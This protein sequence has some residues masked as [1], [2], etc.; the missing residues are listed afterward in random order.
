M[1]EAEASHI[2]SPICAITSILIRGLSTPF[3]VSVA[4]KRIL[5]GDNSH[6]ILLS[7]EIIPMTAEE[8]D[9][10][11]IIHQVVGKDKA[12]DDARRKLVSL[13]RRSSEWL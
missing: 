8:R 5:S 11:K 9:Q 4:G 1:S 7:M 12:V 13:R 10:A 6:L 2:S 3:L